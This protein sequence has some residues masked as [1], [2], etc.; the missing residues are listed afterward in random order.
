MNSAMAG[1]ALIVTLALPGARAVLEGT[2]LTH[3]GVQ[4]VLL[5]V[6]GWLIG[7]ATARPAARL[8]AKYP[9][10]LALLLLAGFTLLFWLLPRYLD[11]ALMSGRWA[12]AKFTTIPLLIGVPIAWGWP[13]LSTVG[14]VFV[15]SNLAA[16]LLAM[17][18]IYLAS[19]DRL[20]VSYLIGD[21]R[22]LG[23][24]LLIL[25]VAVTLGSVAYLL[26]ARTSSTR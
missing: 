1:T 9:A 13:A 12:A 10:G 24:A 23:I 5:G 20:C 11:S 7:S 25:G 14:R 8:A 17:G 15:I 2:M 16:M 3:V 21:Q 6:A 26:R 4:L 18:G 22:L 19:P